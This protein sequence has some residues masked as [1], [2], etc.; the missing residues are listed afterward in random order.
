MHN[1]VKEP[2]NSTSVL[3][4]KLPY[5]E[6]LATE[7][8]TINCNYYCNN[9]NIKFFFLLFKFGDLF[10]VVKE[11]MPKYLRPFVVYRFTYL[12]CNISYIGETTDHLTTRI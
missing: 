6:H 5:I 7:I 10:S 8:K 11:S 4:F 3:Y 9:T 12:D 1:L 2:T